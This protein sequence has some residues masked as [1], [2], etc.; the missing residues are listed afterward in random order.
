MFNDIIFGQCVILVDYY[1]PLFFLEVST[2][3]PEQFC[4]K[5]NLCDETAQVSLSK[6]GDACTLCQDVLGEVLSKLQDPDTEVVV[7]R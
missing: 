2:I 6:S 7:L 1:A 3:S 4:D 5:V